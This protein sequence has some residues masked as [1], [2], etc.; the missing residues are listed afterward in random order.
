M[1]ERR[2]TVRVPY[3]CRTQC[4]SSEDFLPRDG[5]L[6][7]LSEY[8]A[9]LR[10]RYPLKRDTR[11]TLNFPLP[12]DSEPV[13]ATGVIRWLTASPAKQPRWYSYGLEWFSLEEAMRHRLRQ[14]LY[15]S[16]RVSAGTSRDRSRQRP[17]LHRLQAAALVG[18]AIGAGFLILALRTL[19]HENRL[20]AEAVGE[21]DVLLAQAAVRQARLARDLSMT[22]AQL[23]ATSR[24]VNRLDAQARQLGAEV[25]RL[26]D[27]VRYFERSYQYVSA[28]REELIRRVLD[29]E[30]ARSAQLRDEALQ[31]AIQDAIAARQ[32]AMTLREAA[33]PSGVAVGNRG[34][35]V[36]EGRAT[37]QDAPVEIRVL[38]PHTAP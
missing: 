15:N 20:L 28:E 14:F 25:T 23:T 19:R 29:L 3:Q 8:G 11:V 7:S 34:Y 2:T 12:Q 18:A 17:S 4:C 5:E 27:D 36:R 24:D 6:V 38:E 22:H 16:A 13:V 10:T 35:L 26:N 9:N 1:Q 37:G 32:Q 33:L 30:Q 31:R 21:R